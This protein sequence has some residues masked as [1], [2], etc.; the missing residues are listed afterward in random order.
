MGQLI[1]IYQNFTSPTAGKIT[2]KELGV[3]NE[4]CTETHSQCD[5]NGE[6]IVD[7]TDNY[8]NSTF[9]L[10][11]REKLA[12]LEH[13]QESQLVIHA[14]FPEVMHLIAEDSQ[15]NFFK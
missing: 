2:F 3:T 4:K 8:G 10:M 9:V 14:K 1:E 11:D 7:N 6:T 12:K 13:R 15:N 5:F